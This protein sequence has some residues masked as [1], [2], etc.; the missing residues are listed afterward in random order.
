[1]VVV[2]TAMAAMA[3]SSS[4]ELAGVGWPFDWP[5]VG[6]GG[7]VGYGGNGQGLKEVVA[8]ARWWRNSKDNFCYHQWRID[9]GM[10]VRSCGVRA[11]WRSGAVGDA[12]SGK[13]M[14]WRGS[15]A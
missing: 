15:A 8:V 7:S 5:S 11:S 14:T 10:A 4:N 13:A 6:L 12:Q 9:V 2:R 3:T 1:M